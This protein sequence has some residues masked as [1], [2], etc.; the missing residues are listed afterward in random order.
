MSRCL[1][2]TTTFLAAAVLT[3]FAASPAGVWAQGLSNPPVQRALP[4]DEEEEEEIP[5]ATP[6][7][8]DLTP[9]QPA[10]TRKQSTRQD[11]D[12]DIPEG[13]PVPKEAPSIIPR[14]ETIPEGRPVPATN[15]APAKPGAPKQEETPLQG[16]TRTQADARTLYVTLPAPRG[17]IVDRN[18]LPL[19]Q[20]ILA[21]YPGI[22]FPDGE[23]L[24]PAAALAYA[25][26]RIAIA[27]QVL[28]ITWQPKDEDILT[29]Y[30]NRRWLPLLC[31]KVL[32][33]EP[34][35]EQKRR[36]LAGTILHPAYLRT[37]P[38]GRTACHMLGYVG[39]VRPMPTGPLD[40]LDPYYPE[41]QGRGGLEQAYE[42]HLKGK[43]GQMNM[44]FDANGNKITEEITQHPVPGGTLVTTL[45]FDFQQ[46]CEDVLRS[47]VKRGAFVVMDVSTGDVIAMASWPMFDPNSFVP[48]ISQDEFNAL[49]KHKDKPLLGR[50]FMGA[51]PPASTFKVVT[52]LAGMDSG[53][54]SENSAFNCSYSL[55]LGNHYMKNAYK[56]DYGSI[57]LTQA[58]KISCNTWFARAGMA[59]GAENL[60]EMAV[61]LGFSAKTGLP[62]Y[63]EAGLV[64]NDDWM[65]LNQKRR[66]LQGDVANMSIGQGPVSA[67]PLQVARSMAA[68]GNGQF[69]PRT[70]LVS[71]VQDLDNRVIEAF[72]PAIQN[73]LNIR[74][75]YINGVHKGMKAVVNDGGG[76]GRAASN[77]YVKV[78]GK[79]GT[80]QWGVRNMAWFAG[81][82][83]ADKPQY[84]FAAVYEGDFGE[85][86]VSG[87]G[88][89]AP[90][91]SQ[92]FNRVYKLKKDRDEPFY[93]R[94]TGPLLASNDAEDG[95]KADAED[96][97]GE[98]KPRAR[99]TASANK[100]QPAA[101]PE[102]APAAAPQ[103]KKTVKGFFKRLFG[104]S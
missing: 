96:G 20:N 15:P 69:L 61:R 63:E 25:K 81:F 67:T 88:K 89:V 54:F 43:S 57:G 55:R 21:H 74:K 93:K 24:K 58:L 41:M 11:D 70:R 56:G 4:V 73:E 6:V 14:Q 86:R 19:A 18:G 1:S 103:E 10:T 35:A 52:A 80:A 12:E 82:L 26:Q 79:T 9:S 48:S 51:Y 39:R 98:E 65:L 37:Y 59:T 17:L 85:S 44:L 99:K 97:D 34:T 40:P 22:Q 68:I 30:E 46:I 84:A 90:M 87:G 29:H 94:T 3:V 50:A 45:D 92:V 53:K 64:A 49:N 104:R 5:G 8:I 101:K 38:H 72:P 13:R 76:T 78:A 23:P 7:E 102:G 33:T 32:K 83:P 62:F 75:A 66:I 71:Q 42:E 77:K 28:G 60:R 91:V 27:S 36:L 100:P 95:E 47:N 31:D 2:S 16:S